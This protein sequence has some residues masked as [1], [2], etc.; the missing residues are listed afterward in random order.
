MLQT[1]SASIYSYVW[2]LSMIRND[3]KINGGIS[4]AASKQQRHVISRK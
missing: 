1:H 4:E 2:R 3:M